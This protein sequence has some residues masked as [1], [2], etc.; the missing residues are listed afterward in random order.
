MKSKQSLPMEETFLCSACHE[1]LHLVDAY[2]L[3]GEP[4]CE[5]CYDERSV[6]CS[7]CDRMIGLEQNAGTDSLPLCQHCYERHYVKCERCGSL[8]AND[9]AYYDDEDDSA[10]CS[11]CYERIQRNLIH[12]YNY[13][14]CPIF[15]GK[16]DRYFGLELELDDGG[17]EPNHAKVL[18]GIANCEHEHIY[19]KADSSLEDGFE[20]VS[21]PCTL[22]YHR[23]Q[24]PWESVVARAITLGY[25]SHKSTTCGLH[26]HV[27]RT[28]FGA[29]HEEQDACI[30][31]IL[32]FMEKHWGELLKFSRR[33]QAQLNRW[34][35][36]YGLKS[37]PRDVLNHAKK[38]Y[39][40]RYTCL[41][42]Q[43]HATIEFRIFRG[44]L[45]YQT[46]LATLQLVDAICK[47]ALLLSD[48]A[49]MDLSWTSFVEGITS[50]ELI[51]YLKER[52]L[53]IN[54]PILAEEV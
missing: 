48:E 27:N 39:D 9:D 6:V 32:F 35:A 41:N 15:Y 40:G 1:E 2:Y 26:I 36:K 54:E 25:V 38:G 20:V 10:Y 50:S 17:K 21:H 46:I 14:P 28:A 4:L 31:R 33:T 3:E 16:G 51:A 24:L 43:N 18:L 44:T 8:M 34:A 47:V 12:E 52:R 23:K 13:K 22:D 49:L 29:T 42:L 11:T 5:S 45:R 30:G 7:C 53:Y 37:T 19:I